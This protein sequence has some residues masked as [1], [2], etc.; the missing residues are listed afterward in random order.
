MPYEWVRRIEGA[1]ERSAAPSSSGDETLAEL[2]LW[3]YRSLPKRGYVWFIGATAAFLFLPLLELL[4]TP[5]CGAFC[6]S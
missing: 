4:G 5:T 6:P 2:H 3:P 1:A